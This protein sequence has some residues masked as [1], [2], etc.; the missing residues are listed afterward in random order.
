MSIS[1]KVEAATEAYRVLLAARVARS[2]N[3]DPLLCTPDEFAARDEAIVLAQDELRAAEIKVFLATATE[4]GA[5]I[6][7][8]KAGA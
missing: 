1:E 2:V 4:R 7:A 6:A 8:R 3:H 5:R